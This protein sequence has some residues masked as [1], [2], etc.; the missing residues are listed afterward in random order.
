M[1]ARLPTKGEFIA[2]GGAEYSVQF[3]TEHERDLR[4]PLI[5]GKL[6][7]EIFEQHDMWARLALKA[8]FPDLRKNFVRLC[9][10]ASPGR[11]TYYQSNN[12][13]GLGAHR[14][15]IDFN[16]MR[17]LVN[18]TWSTLTE[19]QWGWLGSILGRC[20]VAVVEGRVMPDFEEQEG[21]P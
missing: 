10:D 5:E 1:A 21:D 17:G 13:M 18:R 6:V 19:K 12:P 14:A 4:S 3:Q 8:D 20:G 16:F 9:C 7:L 11:S 15:R 2:N